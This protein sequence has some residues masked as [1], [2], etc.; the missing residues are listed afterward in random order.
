MLLPARGH[1]EY[2]LSLVRSGRAVA[3]SRTFPSD[4]ELPSQESFSTPYRNWPPGSQKLFHSD[5]GDKGARVRK[6][7]H[8]GRG[9]K[10]GVARRPS[11]LLA[12]GPSKGAR[13]LL[14]VL[15]YTKDCRTTPQVSTYYHLSSKGTSVH[16]SPI[17]RLWTE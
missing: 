9:T 1:G 6:V 13:L 8:R 7:H 2:I 3:S 17:I 12:L 11:C 14:T 15:C 4:P 10:I 5:I 16:N